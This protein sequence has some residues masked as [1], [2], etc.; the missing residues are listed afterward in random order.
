VTDYLLDTNVI[1]E[2]TKPAPSPA[3][4]DWLGAQ[5]DRRLF[6]SSLTVGEIRRGI[7]SMPSGRR[8]NALEAWFAGADGPLSLFAGRIMSFGTK[9]A[10]IWADLMAAGDRGGRRRSAIDMMIAAVALA[11][12]CIVV[13]ANAKDFDGIETFYPR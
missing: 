7:L 9:A 8:R 12:D 13:T 11:N 4:L 2:V 1:S 10:M 5:D 3:L 6:I